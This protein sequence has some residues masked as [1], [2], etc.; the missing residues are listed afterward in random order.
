[1]M[2]ITEAIALFEEA[3]TNYKAA[4]LN[5]CNTPKEQM[6]AQRKY[7]ATC[8]ALKGLKAIVTKEPV[9]NEHLQEWQC[10]SCNWRVDDVPPLDITISHCPLCGRPL[11]WGDTTTTKTNSSDLI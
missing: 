2:H 4:L 9:W 7:D 6:D 5:P 3:L 8:L 1:M 10:P 11:H